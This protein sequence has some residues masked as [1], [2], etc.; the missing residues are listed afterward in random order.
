MPG[1]QRRKPKQQRARHTVEVVL[2]GTVRVL[3][4]EGVDAVTTNRIAEA[5]GVSIGSLYQYFP[6]KHSIFKALHARHAQRVR[7]VITETLTR[8][9]GS[10]FETLLLALTD[11]LIDEHAAEPQQLHELLALQPPT[12]GLRLALGELITSKQPSG[13][14]R[15][16]MPG[17]IDALVHDAVLARPAGVSLASAKEETARMIAGYL[18]AA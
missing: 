9:A 12:P 15:F 11:G 18:C 5:A 2:Q 1:T 3:G 4:R 7:Q 13:G 17:V 16:V 14:A 10:P 6:D 8:H